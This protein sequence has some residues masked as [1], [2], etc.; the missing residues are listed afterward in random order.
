MDYVPSALLERAHPPPQV[1]LIKYYFRPQLQELQARRESVKA[2]G[3][4]ALEEWYKGL[5]SSGTQKILDAAR[6]DQ[7]ELQGGPAKFLSTVTGLASKAVSTTDVSPIH[8]PR[9]QTPEISIQARQ[10]P[11]FSL[12]V[13]DRHSP[14]SA[15]MEIDISESQIPA[16]PSAHALLQEVPSLPGR[17]PPSAQRSFPGHHPLASASLLHPPR[18]RAERSM[19]EVE[20][21]KIARR[22]EIEQRCQDLQPP[23]MAST[24][25][26][27]D[28]FK[29]AIQ[30]PLPLNERAWEVLKPRLLA[31][32][33]DAE[34]KEQLHSASGSTTQPEARQQFEEEQRVAQENEINMWH[35]LKVP[36]RERVQRYAQEFI[37]QTWSDGRGVTKATASK[38]A[39]EV[40]CYVRQRFDEEIAREDSMLSLKRTA[41]PQDP[42]SL[43]CRKLKLRDMKWAFEELLK[44]HTERFG[45]DLFLCRVCD[46]NQKLFT[47]EAVIQHYAAKHTHELSHGKAIVYWEADWPIEPPFDPSPNIPWVHDQSHGLLQQDKRQQ[48]SSPAWL[49]QQSGQA[50]LYHN[51]G[52]EVMNLTIE[53]WRR[54]EGVWDMSNS[55][56]LYVVIQHVNA[57]FLRRFKLELGLPLFQDVVATRTELYFLRGVT[58][59]RCRPCSE[60]FRGIPSRLGEMGGIEHSVLDLLSHF[61]HA[62]CD[63]DALSSNISFQGPSNGLRQGPARPDWKREMIWLPSGA[64]I[65]ALQHSRGIDQDKLQI[66]AGAFPDVF[67][68]PLPP[69]SMAQQSDRPFAAVP[70]PGSRFVDSVPA[71]VGHERMRGSGAGYYAARSE[72]S[73]SALEGYDSHRHAAAVPRR[74][75][76]EA[77][78]IMS[79]PPRGVTQYRVAPSHVA[80]YPPRREYRYAAS[81]DL[82]WEARERQGPMSRDSMVYS[83]EDGSS[84]WSYR[85]PLTGYS[86]TTI[87]EARPESKDTSRHSLHLSTASERGPPPSHVGPREGSAERMSTAA[88]DFLANFDPMANEG[89]VDAGDDGLGS[90]GRRTGSRVVDRPGSRPSTGLSRHTPSRPPVL[91][92]ALNIDQSIQER[93]TTSLPVRQSV[94]HTSAGPDED[95]FWVSNSGVH[96][97][98]M[99]QG[100]STVAVGHDY[101][102]GGLPPRPHRVQYES[103]LRGRHDGSIV[104]TEPALEDRYPYQDEY[105]QVSRH[106]EYADVPAQRYS[107]RIDEPGARYVEVPEF[108]GQ[109]Y[110]EHRQYSDRRSRGETS[111]SYRVEDDDYQLRDSHAYAQHDSHGLREHVVEARRIHAVAD[112]GREI[113]YEPVHGPKRYASP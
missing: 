25:P 6:F 66:I 31:Q 61:Q 11:A 97:D 54:T 107:Y 5:E 46:T 78:S 87:S 2:L 73:V 35:E 62:H 79:S 51:H 22:R 32:R 67:A 1:H 106:Y 27:M 89:S 76:L 108:G 10:K 14:S 65:R 104:H 91:D 99:R 88:A 92:T 7:W 43:A 24:L 98:P 44:P 81:A 84:R 47:F 58:G 3:A 36:S 90:F 64:A 102:A 75:P 109:P 30:I 103:E 52:N 112:D 40:L 13:S 100:H 82:S 19:Q 41:F 15:S 83:Y 57:G 86:D 85:E 42:E 71:R 39:A 53:H 60:N 16:A 33:P 26:Y 48:S 29:A 68:H 111:R 8:D 18:Q 17:Q 94:R 28:A 12:S 21:A 38:F 93:H 4:P 23:I 59:L 80:T 113:V 50:G 105:P 77:R 96:G 45:K 110:L 56:R 74:G 55:V 95:R 37:H 9:I 49:S 72:G 101:S 63:S 34:R 70:L 69:A 20:H